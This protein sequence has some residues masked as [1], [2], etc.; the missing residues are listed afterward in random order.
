MACIDES[1]VL[2]AVVHTSTTEEM[3]MYEYERRSKFSSNVEE[4]LFIYTELYLV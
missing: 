4:F 3:R 2:S 1:R